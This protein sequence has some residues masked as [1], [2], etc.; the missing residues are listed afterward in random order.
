M[1]VKSNNKMLKTSLK[2]SL[3]LRRA[4]TSN[5]NYEIFNRANTTKIDL[6]K[7]HYEAELLLEEDDSLPKEE[8][9][10]QRISVNIFQFFCHL[11]EPID[12]LYLVL[13]MIGMLICGASNPVMNYLN[14]TVYS[15]IGNTSENRGSLTEEEIM[16]LNVKKTM[17]SNIKKQLVCGCISFVGNL[18]GYS[19][20]GLF[21]TRAL[22][23][24]K[25]KYFRTILSQELG[26]FDST[27]VFEFASKIQAQLEYI[28]FGIGEWFNKILFSSFQGIFTFI[29]SFFGSWKLSLILLCLLP[30]VIILAII[31]NKINTKGNSLVR[32]TWEI[33][34]G[35]GEEI[36]Y[37]IKT[38]VSFSNFEYELKRFY[39]KVEISNK[40]E[41]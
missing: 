21:S 26:W 38:V 16:K 8:F 11:F 20:V 30:F 28:E 23:N 31:F 19:L 5:Y 34:G 6:E 17:N 9:M 36:F 41:L 13:G 29:F 10:F 32:Q 2:N 1:K 4:P 33:A 7:A 39:E 27:N 15:D 14:A 3:S 40:I 18:M 35:I 22:Y 24:F 12:W 25:R 37:N